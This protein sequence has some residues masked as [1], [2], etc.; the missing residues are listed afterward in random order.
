MLE[1]VLT[2]RGLRG[3]LLLTG[4][5]LA[6]T[7]ACGSESP[8]D[9]DS[10]TGTTNPTTTNP[11]TTTETSESS[12]ETDPSGTESESETAGPTT[13]DPTTEDPT[14]EDPTTEDPTTEDPTTE[15]TDAVCPQ[16][17]IVCEGNE[18]KVCDGMGGFDETE[19]CDPEVCVDGLGCVTCEPGSTQCNGEVVETCN[20]QGTGWNPGVEC[21][22]LQ[23]TTC[24]PD[25]GN[26]TG[27]CSS[28]SLGTSYIGCDYYPTVTS[29]G[30]ATTFNFAVTVANTSDNQATVTVTRGAN[31]VSQVNVAANS[32]Q[33]I[34]LPWVEPLKGGES[35][36]STWPTV[37]VD[38]GA[39]R[40]RSNE[41]VT[42]YQYSPI[43]YKGNG[44][45][46]AGLTLDCSFTNDASLLLP[47]NVWRD[48]YIVASRN[49]LGDQIPGFYAVVASQDDT[50]VNLT[51]SATGGLVVGGAGVS[52]NGTGAV[53]LNQGDVLQVYSTESQ[54][55]D[56]TGTIVD[57]DKPIQVFGGHRCIYVPNETPYCDHIEESMPPIASLASSY[58]VTAPLIRILNNDEVTGTMVRIVAT[59]DNTTLTYD[60]PQGGAPTNLAAAGNFAEIPATA[61]DFEIN[62][63][64]KVLVVQYMRGQEATL[65]T[66]G[67]PAMAVAVP[68]QQFRTEYLFHAPTNYEYNYV[69]IVAPSGSNITLDG[70]A[71]GNFS[72]IGGTGYG[73]SR[74]LLNDGNNGNHTISGDQAFGISVYGYGVDTSY[75]YPGGLDLKVIE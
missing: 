35:L 12:G 70:N 24:D 58:I 36:D 15:T 41:P 59:E 11:T 19:L 7:T 13:E 25:I 62:A 67:D 45:C 64:K 46:Q 44:I 37:K 9:T 56:L 26:C 60:P 49:G 34:N 22:P 4:C 63:D 16:G 8:G 20:G 3:P 28:V 61:N 14:T 5:L 31:M 57:S 33:I 71:V 1:L 39:Y 23:G 65:S 55:A 52:N 69:N 10:N 75:W 68:T 2:R 38:D 21:D 66:V 72:N 50:T 40:L 42:V 73:V 32:L 53:T 17:E 47:T 30:V 51:P 6:L 29:N 74:V 27:K 48:Q 18:A 43:E 54:Q